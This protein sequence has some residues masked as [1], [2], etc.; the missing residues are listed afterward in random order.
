[1]FADSVMLSFE[2]DISL[3]LLFNINREYYIFNP[4]FEGFLHSSELN[5][6]HDNMYKLSVAIYKSLE[7][8]EFKRGGRI[9]EQASSLH[10]FKILII[11]FQLTWRELKSSAFDAILKSHGHHFASEAQLEH[12]VGIL[13][14]KIGDTV[15]LVFGAQ[16]L[17][18]QSTLFHVLHVKFVITRHV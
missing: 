5:F 15:S 11:F 1:M 7:R 2:E 3:S 17:W 18:I 14:N 9:S 13:W 6:K 10:N 4:I 8:L 12:V 16:L